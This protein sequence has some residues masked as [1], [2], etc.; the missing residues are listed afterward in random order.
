MAFLPYFL[1]DLVV[2]AFL[3]DEEGRQ[4]QKVDYTRDEFAR[5]S[6][7]RMPTTLEERS[8]PLNTGGAIWSTRAPYELGRPDDQPN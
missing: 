7:R 6:A 3:E 4:L 5:I 2:E 1:P 8:R